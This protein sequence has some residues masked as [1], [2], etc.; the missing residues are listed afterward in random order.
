MYYLSFKFNLQAFVSFQY[1]FHLKVKARTKILFFIQRVFLKTLLFIETKVPTRT[2]IEKQPKKI[3]SR[4][5]D[6]FQLRNFTS[7]TSTFCNE[8]MTIIIIISKAIKVLSF[9]F[10][11]SRS[12]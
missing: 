6:S 5:I 3:N 12:I 1:E 7:I 10:I 4:D 2:P 11:N 9:I 8:N